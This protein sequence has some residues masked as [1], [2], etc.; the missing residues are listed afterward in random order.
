M[1]A[2]VG[3]LVSFDYSPPNFLRSFTEPCQF[4]KDDWFENPRDQGII[5]SPPGLQAHATMPEF[6]IWVLNT[7]PS[8]L[9]HH[10]SFSHTY[11]HKTPNTYPRALGSHCL[12]MSQV[13]QI[14]TAEQFYAGRYHVLYRSNCT[15]GC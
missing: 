13:E 11:K 14:P 3:F 2:E 1:R 6:F 15:V 12:N 9:R 5:L 10:P 7:V 8:Q 4:S